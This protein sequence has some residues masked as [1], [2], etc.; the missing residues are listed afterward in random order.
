MFLW[1][2]GIVFVGG[3]VWIALSMWLDK[4]CDDDDGE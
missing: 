3:L 1:L 2:L 4:G